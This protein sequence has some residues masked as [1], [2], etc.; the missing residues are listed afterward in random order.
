MGTSVERSAPSSVT[1][2]YTIAADLPFAD[3]LAAG[4]L[5]SYA[6][7]D[8][9]LA[10]G[11]VTILLPT[12]RGCRALQRAF[13]RRS[14]GRALLLPRLVPLGD[15]DEGEFGSMA[16][17]GDADELQPVSTV[18]RKLL[19]AK[20]IEAHILAARRADA[21]AYE[22]I[23]IDQAVRLADALAHLLDQVQT[24]QLSFDGLLRL[25]PSDYAE[26][27]QR[28]LRFLEV[29]T[30]HWPSILAE[31]GHVDP[32]VHRNAKLKRLAAGWQS[33]PPQH[34]VIAAG[35]TGSVPATANLL[36]VVAR[37]SSG[38]VVL[39][40]LD[41]DLDQES[42]DCLGPTHPQYQ[43]AQLLLQLNVSREQVAVWPVQSAWGR[44]LVRR[45]SRLRLLREVT[46]PPETTGDPTQLREIP[47]Q[48]WENIERIDCATDQEE[49]GVVALIM[50]SVLAAGSRDLTGALVTPDRQLA[51]RVAAELSRWQVSVDDSAGTPI[52]DT[53]PGL[54]LRLIARAFAE[55]FAPVPL[56]AML[57]HPIARG[58]ED[59]GTFRNR[60]RQLET[61]ILRGP[62]PAPDF[63]GLITAIEASPKSS[64]ELKSWVATWQ[65][66]A[67]AMRQIMATENHPLG[68]L[69]DA[70]LAFAE[71]LALDNRG[72]SGLWTDE[73]GEALAAFVA[74]VSNAAASS[75]P[76]A[77]H[78]Y[79][80]LLDAL[81]ADHVVRPRYGQH[82]RLAILG[83]LEARLQQYDVMILGG[84]NEGTWPPEADV[85]PWMSRQMRG[86]FGLAP[87][88]RR[89]GQSAHDFSVAFGARQVYL[90]RA[91]RVEGTPTVASRWLTRLD[92]IRR[93]ALQEAALT[94]S[95]WPVWW[96]RIDHGSPK[97]ALQERP[98]A[99]R[100]PV[101]ARPRKLSV[102]Q[103][104]RWLRDP[105]EIYAKHVLRLKLLDPIDADPGAAEYGQIVHSVLDRFVR[106]L[107]SGPLPADAVTQLLAIGH[108]ELAPLKARPGVW[109]FWWPRFQRI[110]R[111]FVEAERI[112]RDRVRDS[113]TEIRGELTLDGPAG[114][115]VL[116][117]VADR[118]DRMVAG[119][120]EIIDYKTGAVPRPTEIEAGL[121][122][123]LPLEAA[124]VRGGGFADVGTGPVEALLYWRLRGGDP[125]GEIVAV[126]GIPEQLSDQSLAGL[127]RLIAVFDQETTAY[128]CRPRPDIAPRFSDYIHLAR[129]PGWA[130]AGEDAV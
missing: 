103:V 110:A 28:T 53:P 117:A 82:P 41:R 15:I 122:P 108:D 125:A 113:F 104:E 3:Y 127:E 87:P 23:T 38:A 71:Q 73:A 42:W 120:T 102:T 9:P 54:F 67:E 114:P 32:V 85:D 89:I 62:R 69:L 115:F 65:S 49:A 25:V 128:V 130:S 45:P 47:P 99:P 124:I 29:L 56:L 77:T 60:V 129:V 4:V 105:Y 70:H 58:G 74:D 111:W 84:L 36:G 43:L 35:S 40:A 80:A 20:L 72:R 19:L 18:R 96:Q 1:G 121:A 100:P 97:F 52:A 78:R 68:R 17:A 31:I 27:W 109:A 61:A 91:L 11:Q 2:V 22:D 39:P 30:D 33:Q 24:E 123:Q 93:I 76:V 7:D 5:E 59:A 75:P 48:A 21:F 66:A 126:D 106:R 6:R 64:A 88:D 118:I 12:R 34:P 112:Q 81:M 79:P 101:T 107:P 14:D 94:R 50:R 16:F 8:D 37:L 63:A 26:H 57:K 98:P 95:R 46:R 55:R 92:N 44:S 116:S 51:R 13:L 10:L 86:A 90:T 119:G 83:P